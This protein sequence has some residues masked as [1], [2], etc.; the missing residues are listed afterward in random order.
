M[1]WLWG[2]Y[3]ARGE[4]GGGTGQ[5]LEPKSKL[6]FPSGDEEREFGTRIQHP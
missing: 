3:T 5:R 2:G 4:G 1:K 6:S